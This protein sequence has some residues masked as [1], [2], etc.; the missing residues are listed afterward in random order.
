ML[1]DFVLENS[2][3]AG[4]PK[5]ITC[6]PG[7]YDMKFTLVE[8]RAPAVIFPKST[9]KT[10]RLITPGPTNIPKY[11]PKPAFTFGMRHSPCSRPYFTEHEDK[12]P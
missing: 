9:Y 8:W 10:K 7:P 4:H 6:S 3:K 5:H 11:D 12:C 2:G 1:I